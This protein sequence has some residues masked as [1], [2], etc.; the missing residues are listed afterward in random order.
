MGKVQWD[1]SLAIGV[2]LIDQQHKTLVQRL[3]DVCA[4]VE[5]GHGEH[6]ILMTLGFLY[7]YADLHFSVEEKHMAEQGFPGL[8]LQ[9]T[10]HAEFMTAVENLE[11]D[12]KEEGST[13]ALAEA[14]NTFLLNWLTGH[15]RGLDHQFAGFLDEKG[16]VI[17]EEA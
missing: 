10:K 5:A 2:P 16:V 9:K 7:D 3:N 6:E 8:E 12:F 13:H 17:P 15:I 4:A 14:V 11:Q 1:D